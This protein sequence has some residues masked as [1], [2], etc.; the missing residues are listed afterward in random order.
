MIAIIWEYKVK[1]DSAEPF[2]KLYGSHGEWVSLF[3]RFS[4]FIGT[5]LLK[6]SGEP[7][8]YLTIDRWESADLYQ[9]F[10]AIAREEYQRIDAK[11]EVMVME[12]NKIGGYQNCP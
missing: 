2:E 12:E 7:G 9:K 11:G 8:T 4:G 10:L 3:R 1:P 5:E 6:N